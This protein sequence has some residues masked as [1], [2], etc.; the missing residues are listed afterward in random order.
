MLGLPYPMRC[1]ADILFVLWLSLVGFGCTSPSP[2]T[3]NLLI[4]AI[5][6]LRADRLGAYG[7]PRGLTPFLDQ[8][9]R[10]GTMF[11]R[12]Y[13]T[14]SWTMPSVASYFTSRY[15]TQHRV[16]T[17]TSRLPESEVTLAE[18]LHEHGW[19]CG[20]FSANPNLRTDLGFGQGF[21]Q[22]WWDASGK[23]DVPGDAVRVQSLAW[24]D[25]HW[26]RDTT[27]PVFLYV[28]YM[29]PH[30]PYQPPDA[31]RVRFAVDEEGH[32][33]ERET[34]LQNFVARALPSLSV[35]DPM[36]PIDVPEALRRIFMRGTPL[37]R[38]EYL[39]FERLYDAEVAAAD[40]Q[41][42][43]LWEALAA[44]GFLDEA[45]VILLSDHGEE[46]AE[47]GGRAHGRALYEESVR[48]P[49]IVL[50]PGVAP[51]RRVPE[52]VSLVDLVPTLVDLLQLPGDTRL[53]GL[54]LA[55]ALRQASQGGSS[56]QDIVLQLDRSSGAQD[57]RVHRRGLVRERDKLLVRT[58]DDLERYDLANDPTELHDAHQIDAA[59][60]AGLHD[61]LTALD[62]QLG[63]RANAAEEMVPIDEGLKQRLR[64]LGYHP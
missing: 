30:E 25:T 64:A 9:A 29:E 41:V 38:Y 5:D 21:D 4:V 24:L 49:F 60:T 37:T 46:F 32:P 13:A 11:E 63:G 26:R 12:A 33:F 19:L 31:F 14:T 2:H 56:V 34:V 44:R 53:E 45:I 61:A 35:D 40:D 42:R 59:R 7:N 39:P 16:T 43:Q 36:H 17:L 28:H 58:N 27:A 6:T 20:G 8:L 48:V 57:E 51:G 15:P 10:R 54:S 18:R 55:P 52:N 1:A 22:L 62:G 23:A 3:P 47:H 50:G